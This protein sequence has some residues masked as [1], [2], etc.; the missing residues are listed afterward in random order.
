MNL[1]LVMPFLRTKD[2]VKLAQCAE[3]LGLEGVA[4]GDHVC[5][6]AHVASVYPYSGQTADLPVGTEFPDPIGLSA[7]LGASTTALRFM[8]YVL[9]VPLRHPVLLAKRG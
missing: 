2:L 3:E 7:A 8:T 1:W 9:L 5:V 4:V 6:P